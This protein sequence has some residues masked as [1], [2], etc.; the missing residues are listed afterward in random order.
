VDIG[1][2]RIGGGDKRLDYSVLDRTI[3][4]R[5]GINGGLNRMNGVLESDVG[6]KIGKQRGN[7]VSRDVNGN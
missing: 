1:S 4:V 7:V 2:L 5:S 3:G 6:V